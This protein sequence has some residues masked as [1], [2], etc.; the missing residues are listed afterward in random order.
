MPVC[1]WVSGLLLCALAGPPLDDPRQDPYV[2]LPVLARL[3]EWATFQVSFDHDSMVPDMA[4]GDGLKQVHGKPRFADGLLGRALVCGPESGFAL[5]PRERNATFATRGAVS[6]WIRPLEWTRVNGGNTEFLMLSNYSVYLERQGPAHNAEGQV[7][8]QEG[9]LYLL[10]AKSTGTLC[11][12]AG[13]AD[14]PNGV[15]RLVVCNWSWPSMSLS[16]DGG[17]FQSLSAKVAPQPEE[18][19]DLFIGAP[20][21]GETALL[22]EVTF[23]RRPLSQDEARALYEALCPDGPAR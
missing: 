6:L 13:T 12:Q 14:W 16:I 4:A 9:L 7:T 22:D 1:S 17:P 10:L 5:Y 11:L 3:M 2:R 19:G 23:Y 8:R 20:S 18:F 15:W 21:G